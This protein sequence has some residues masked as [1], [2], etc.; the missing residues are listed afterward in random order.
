MNGIGKFGEED[1]QMMVK[2]K[3]GRF[4]EEDQMF[5]HVFGF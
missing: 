2:R 1:V 3:E 4:G 5:D